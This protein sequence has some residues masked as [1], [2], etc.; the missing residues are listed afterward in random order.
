MR[1]KAKELQRQRME[2]N[3]KGFMKGGAGGFGGPGSGFGSSSSPFTPSPV[4]G[5][6]SSSFDKLRSEYSQM[7]VVPK[8]C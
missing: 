3:K 5:D 4:I 6:S 1:E 2:A 7:Y 8:F